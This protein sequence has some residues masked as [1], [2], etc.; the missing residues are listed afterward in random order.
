MA[1]V[2][3]GKPIPEITDLTRPFWRA[4]KQ[5]KLVMQKC[6]RCGTL[7]F[8]PKPWCIECGHRGLEWVEVGP[9][10][11]VYSYTVAYTVMMN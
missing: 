6:Q 4:A 7:D 8:F 3:Q 10:G 1:S 5:H 11:T 9:R 2:P